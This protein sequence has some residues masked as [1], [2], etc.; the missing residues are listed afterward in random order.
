MSS[1]DDSIDSPHDHEFRDGVR[2]RSA[3]LRVL[4]LVAVVVL[5]VGGILLFGPTSHAEPTGSVLGLDNLVSEN[6]ILNQVPASHFTLSTDISLVDNH[7]AE[8]SV[9][10]TVLARGTLQSFYG[11]AHF[12]SHR[13]VVI[14]DGSQNV[15]CPNGVSSGLVPLTVLTGFGYQ[16]PNT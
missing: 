15:G 5:T 2:E 3:I 6:L 4:V 16:C 9:T 8:F 11:F 13:W 14:T 10:P 12:Q 7:W 1:L